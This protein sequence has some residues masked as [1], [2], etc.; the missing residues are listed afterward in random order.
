MNP[1]RMACLL[2]CMLLLRSWAAP[3]QNFDFKPPASVSDPAMP[4]VMRDLAERIL[5]VYQEENPERYL[6]SL[7]ALQLV[8][9]NYTAASSSRQ[10]LRD[11]RRAAD[12]SRPVSRNLILDMYTHARAIEATNRVPFAQA[13]TT[14]Y[15]DAVP[16]LNDLDA[17]ILTG[18]LATPLAAY[19]DPVQRI[20]DQRRPKGNIE[21]PEALQ[22]IQ[23]YA[24]YDAYR[25]FGPIV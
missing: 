19:R 9:G 18:W 6:A 15:K 12:A 22:L 1:W 23:E 3:A 21:L 10:S 17:Y 8:A 2:G 4:A 24:L 25:N 7:S 14:A 16:K 20:L 11:R 13:F 5:P